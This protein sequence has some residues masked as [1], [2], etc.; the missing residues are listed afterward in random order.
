MMR[1]RI[2]CSREALE[3]FQ[4]VTVNGKVIFEDKDRVVRIARA[5][6][7]IVKSA[8][9]PLFDGKSIDE[10]TKE[11][12]NILPNYV[13]LETALKQ[14]K[15]IVDG[16]LEREEEK[17][18][19]IHARIRRFWFGSRGNKSDKGNRNVKFHVL[20]D[21]VL[22]KVKDPWGKWVFGKAYFGKE[23]LPLLKELEELSRRKEEGYGAVI[24]FK[25]YPMIHL[26]IPLWLY[27]KHFSLPKPNGYGLIAGFDL[28]SD[29]L[30]VVVVNE[31]GGVVTKKTWWYSDVTRPGFLRGKAMALRLNALS[32]A[33][34]FLS[35]IGVDYVAF[36]DLFLV[37]RRKFTR[38]KS[39]NRKVSRFAKRQLLIHGVIKALRLGFNVILVNPK[40]TTNSEGHDKVM[41]EKG[42]DR[43]TASAYLI[44]L[45]GL[46]MLNDI[47]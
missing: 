35:R 31:E 41:R 13:Y 32:Q 39:G 46:G 7:Q 36:E 12:Y 25:H 33:L 2:I 29:R 37:K 8:I 24:S 1:N 34:I 42:F 19:I 45:K 3:N 30:N 43:H 9:K 15:T 22:I 10:L 20:E 47:K 16:L 38:S 21:H 44:A 14:A 40:G 28:N 27:L 18:K 11:F 17:G 26:Q 23:Y 4:F 5:Y 6:S